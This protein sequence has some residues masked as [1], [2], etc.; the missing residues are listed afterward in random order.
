M[1]QA[2]LKGLPAEELP[3]LAE[4]VRA[5]I[6]ET[7]AANG[8]HLA[9]SLGTVELAI[10]L[11][12]TFDPPNDTIL[13]DVGHQ[14]YAWKILTG[15]GEEFGHLRRFGGLSGF[16]NPEESPCDA[17]VAGHAGSALAAAEGLA[18]ARDRLGGGHVVAVI[19]DA[20]LT[21]GESMEALNNCTALTGKMIIVVNDN[22]MSIS[23]NVGAFARVL[24]RLL[25]DV[26]YN[27]TKSAAERAGH[28]MRLTFLRSVYHRVERMIKSFWLGN[29]LFE[30]FGLRYVG[31]VDGHD[32]K[33]V[34]SALTVAKEDKRSVVVHIVTM[35]GKGFPPA[36]ANPTAWHGVGPFDLS[37]YK[38]FKDL[39]DLEDLK[40]LKDLKDVKD[41]KDAG[42]SEVFGAAVCAAARR[43]PRVCALTAAMREGTGLAPFAREF[44]DRFFDV[45]ICEEHLV[46][47]AAGLAKGGMKPVVA[48]YS[49]FL[50]RAVDQVMHDVCLLNLPVVFGVDR[51]G[52][53]G[54]DGRTHHG[55]FDIPMLRCLPNL[56]ILQPKDAEELEAMLELA[57]ARNAPVA[58]R[59]PR[60]RPGESKAPGDL[61]DFK[62]FKDLKD[63]NDLKWGCAEQMSKPDAPL[64]IWALGDQVEKAM[65]AA[66]LL[67][68]RGVEAGVVNARF[69][70]PFDA[71]LLARQRAAGARIASLE[72]GAATGG[73]GEAIGADVRFGWPDSYIQHGSV[74]ELEAA[75]GLDAKSIADR[76]FQS[77]AQK[78]RSSII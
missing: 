73:F 68:A 62:D 58:I 22:A 34:T 26:R 3:A 74:P 16:P 2:E 66:A 24:G 55:M 8:G 75:C 41:L 11:L 44:P 32:L 30:S 63:V 28:L 52:A 50:Q 65:A 59:Y 10:G 69:V 19:G 25:A 72:N 49:T 43:D 60:G 71:G 61:N 20:S 40:D 54:A 35:K 57:L 70:K 51:A 45:G 5:K 12:R 39:K 38:N 17:F 53:V 67:A 29:T 6:L 42:W 27:R 15:R 1:T 23:R 7:V 76:L 56:S 48:V 21:N 64:Q 13:W 46:T 36:E 33:A 77:Q 47:F 9:S 18:A 78:P 4:R 37:S 31:P 14:A